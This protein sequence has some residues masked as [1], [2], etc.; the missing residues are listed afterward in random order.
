MKLKQFLDKKNIRTQVININNDALLKEA[1]GT[2]K[3][4]KFYDKYNKR[5][6]VVQ[7]IDLDSNKII[8]DNQ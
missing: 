5:D 8:Q 4:N 2:K 6:Y 1:K 7:I 3:Y